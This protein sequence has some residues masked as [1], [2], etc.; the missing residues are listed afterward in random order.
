M[1]QVPC[2]KG[3]TILVDECD[4]G[5]VS[6]YK[7]YAHH[8]SKGTYRPARRESHPPRKVVFLSQ[9]IIDAP[10]G[11]HRDHINGDPFDNRRENLRVCEHNQNMKNR[12]KHGK[13]T[14]NPHKGVFASGKKWRVFIT[15]DG[16]GYV[17]GSFQSAEQAASAY[18]AAAI[19]LHGEY[20]RLNFPDRHTVM[21]TP[22]ILVSFAKFLKRKP[23]YFK[24]PVYFK[25]CPCCGYSSLEAK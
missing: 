1:K 4:Y 7:W 13:T 17:C 18:D 5:K 11:M 3:Y 16:V 22:D 6:Q 2:T 9:E 23:T 25:K 8:S 21:C 12:K 14:Q 24:R 10:K 15:S 19:Y 20:G